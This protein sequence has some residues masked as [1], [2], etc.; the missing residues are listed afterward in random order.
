MARINQ[1]RGMTELKETRSWDASGRGSLIQTDRID[2]NCPAGWDVV[3]P[4]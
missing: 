1:Y 4:E 3:I 2:V